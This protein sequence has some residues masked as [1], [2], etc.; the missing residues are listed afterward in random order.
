MVGHLNTMRHGQDTNGDGIPDCAE[1]LMNRVQNGPGVPQGMNQNGLK[2]IVAECIEA[3]LSE[4]TAPSL[5]DDDADGIPDFV[6]PL[7]VCLETSIPLWFEEQGQQV[8]Q[9]DQDHDGVADKIEDIVAEVVA[10]IPD[11]L[12]SLDDPDV[13]DVNGNGIPDYLENLLG[14]GGTPNNVDNDG[15]GI[16]DFAQDSDGD[17]I[18]NCLDEDARHQ[19][20]CDGD[21]VPNECDQDKDNDGVPNYA[22]AD[23]CDPNIQ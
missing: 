11:W 8:P 21:G 15:D 18:P 6:A 5:T 3:W 14:L 13:I 2:A 9:G 12:A 1:P 7:I 16:P 4:L 17:G 19:Y 20:D 22:D 10:G 23:Q